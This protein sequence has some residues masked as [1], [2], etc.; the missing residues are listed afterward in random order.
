MKIAKALKLKNRLA[1]EIAR[2][3]GI[4]QGKNVTEVTQK[5]VYDVKKIVTVD[6]PKAIGSLVTVKT[7]I[8][9]SNSGVTQ[10]SSG[11][12]NTSVVFR[13]IFAMAEKKGM[14]ETLRAMDTKDGTYNEARGRF[15]DL[16]TA[17]AITYVAAFKQ[18]DVDELVAKYERDIDAL[19]DAIDTHNAT[20]DW[21]VLDSI[22]I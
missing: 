5:P 19:Q 14:I 9:M 2:L 7:I 3:K 16:A 13:S 15:G 11:E 12:V 22:T 20:S 6:L 18:S 17:N 21:S 1:G 8:A 10:G 4:A